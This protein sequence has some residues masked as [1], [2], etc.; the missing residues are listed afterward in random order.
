MSRLGAVPLFLVPILLV[1]SEGQQLGEAT[2]PR[3]G[4]WERAGPGTQAGQ[5]ASRPGG[6]AAPHQGAN[7]RNAR[8][9]GEG[10]QDRRQESV[11]RRR[12]NACRRRAVSGVSSAPTVL[13]TY[14]V[15]PGTG[16]EGAEIGPVPAP[17]TGPTSGWRTGGGRRRR[18][19]GH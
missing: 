12:E 4:G 2:K 1:R 10:E 8:A 9:A 18:Q 11:G 17:W 7:T 3:R 6:R 5:Q 16:F 14:P 13:A 19:L 15:H